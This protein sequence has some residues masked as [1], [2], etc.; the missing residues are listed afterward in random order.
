MKDHPT[1]P[2][3][4][5]EIVEQMGEGWASEYWKKRGSEI[6]KEQYDPYRFGYEPPIWKQADE[7][8]KAFRAKHPKGVLIHLI[9]GGHRAGKSEWRAK[10]TVQALIGNPDY[11]VWACQATQEASREAQQSKI[12]RYLPPE[13]KRP[14]TGR[15]RRGTTT[16]VV[17]T[18]WGGFTEDVL[19]LPTGDE[20]TSECRF[21][22]YSMNA[23]SL[24][25]AEI[26][27]AWL[28][29]EASLEWL[30]AVL[31]R[32]VTRNGILYLTFTPRWGYTQ[33]VKALL[34]G[35]T[36]VE[37]KDAELLIMKDSNGETLGYEKVPIT[38][39]NNAVNLPGQRA[40]AVITYFHTKD[41]PYGGYETMSATLDGASREKILTVAYGV[42]TRA[43]L[44]QFPMFNDTVH[45]ISLNRFA[46][47]QKEGGTWYHFVDPC[48]GRNWFQIWI[49]IDK[50]NRAFVR[51]ESPSHGHNE[52][53]IPGVGDP[54]PWAVAGNKDDGDKGEGQKEWGWGYNR[55]LEEIARVESLLGGGTE[56]KI[57]A[58]WIDARYANTSSI[59]E[60]RSITMIEELADLGMFFLAAPSE[61]RI[62]SGRGGGDGSLRM[63]NDRLYYNTDDTISAMNEPHLYIVET[64]PNVIFALKEWTGRDGQH[65]ASKDPIDTLR[66]FTLSG[67]EYIDEKLMRPVVHPNFRR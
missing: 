53:Y 49:F 23:R 63:I 34:S 35:A 42:P 65:G 62:D 14:E 33:T 21:K 61:Q 10:R 9:L 11:K 18:P 60:E 22:F 27:E 64:C 25:G 12:Y 54:G 24:E 51:A 66:M 58:R 15:L 59:R 20:G 56:V 7:Q 2:L 13:Y 67:S 16:K 39:E 28:D 43:M 41:N 50:R 57:S 46:E 29:E 37:E 17:Y 30:D 45:I 55:Y 31:Y 47:I 19:S 36:T 52:A 48:S 32:L 40:K 26:D 6:W 3:L 4:P 44:S 38:Q 5:T 8:I 1:I